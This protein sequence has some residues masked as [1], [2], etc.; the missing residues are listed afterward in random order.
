M[1]M[2]VGGMAGL[3]T[4]MNMLSVQAQS[5]GAGLSTTLSSGLSEEPMTESEAQALA[6]G[7]LAE[8]SIIQVKYESQSLGLNSGFYNSLGQLGTMNAISRGLSMGGGLDEII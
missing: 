2:T 8:S 6:I 5:Q 3:N 7:Q 4:R 1:S